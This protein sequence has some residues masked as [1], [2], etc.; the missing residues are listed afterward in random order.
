MEDDLFD[1][2]GMSFF[3]SG[4]RWC[5]LN[6]VPC[7]PLSTCTSYFKNKTCRYQS[8]EGTEGGGGDDEDNE[9]EW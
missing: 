8:R 2:L 4:G 5:I 6:N 7:I 9:R 3:G 1:I